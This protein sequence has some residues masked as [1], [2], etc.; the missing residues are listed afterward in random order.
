MYADT[1]ILHPGTDCFIIKKS[2]YEKFIQS[3]ACLGALCVMKSLLYNM[4]AMSEK[5]VIIPDAHATFH[6][7]DDR[8]WKNS[9]FDEYAL[10]NERQAKMVALKLINI[11]NK[12]KEKLKHYSLERNEIILFDLVGVS[13]VYKVLFIVKLRLKQYAIRLLKLFRN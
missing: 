3:D 12:Y 11:S 5:M 7:G 6:I 2:I 13:K 10:H 8:L 4:V 9:D 1:G